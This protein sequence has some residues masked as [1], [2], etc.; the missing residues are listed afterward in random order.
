MQ[1]NIDDIRE[2]NRT[3]SAN[4]E[5]LKELISQQ[6]ENLREGESDDKRDK[7]LQEQI[8]LVRESVTAQAGELEG[9]QAQ[10]SELETRL[11]NRISE[12]EERVKAIMDKQNGGAGE[13]GEE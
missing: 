8:A 12:L 4:M 6:T 7:S 9:L 11:C 13:G 2:D 5:G 1:Q 3:L 10:T